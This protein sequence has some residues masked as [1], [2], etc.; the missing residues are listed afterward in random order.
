MTF[1]SRSHICRL[2]SIGAPKPRERMSA[3]ARGS[4][5]TAAFSPPSVVSVTR[6]MSG[7]R[8][9]VR[10]SRQIGARKA[11]ATTSARVC[12][13]R[14]A[15]SRK[16][17]GSAT[18]G[19]QLPPQHRRRGRGNRRRVRPSRRIR[20]PRR[21]RGA[22]PNRRR[23]NRRRATR[24]WTFAPQWRETMSALARISHIEAAFSRRSSVFVT[25]VKK[26]RRRASRRR[27]SRR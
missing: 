9:R 26:Q 13:S 22:E 2:N 4:R 14:A 6:V 19:P 16:S 20:S 18:R 3:L 7:H 15:S 27:A 10:L 1:H 12:A 17:A 8:H 11:R 25:R 21:P 5:A 24:R 23:A